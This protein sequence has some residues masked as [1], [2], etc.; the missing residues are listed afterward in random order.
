MK[1]QSTCND[2]IF[3]V[4]NYLVG[5][6]FYLKNILELKSHEKMNSYWAIVLFWHLLFLWKKKIAHHHWFHLNS[7]CIEQDGGL[8]I[9]CYWM[10]THP[11]RIA[12]SYSFPFI[13]SILFSSRIEHLFI[14]RNERKNRLFSNTQGL[15]S[16]VFTVVCFSYFGSRSC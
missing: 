1:L 4:L 7:T 12:S 11:N 10:F 14:T 6:R 2:L 16:L 15:Y 8:V 13:L 3:N 9:Q 5:T